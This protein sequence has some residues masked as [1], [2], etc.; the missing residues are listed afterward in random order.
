[1]ERTHFDNQTLTPYKDFSAIDLSKTLDVS[2][3]V[4]PKKDEDNSKISQP[5][6]YE[7]HSFISH[8]GEVGTSTSRI[9]GYS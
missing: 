6:I 8:V 1:M 7:L 3:C 4:Y 5:T 9:H 2:G